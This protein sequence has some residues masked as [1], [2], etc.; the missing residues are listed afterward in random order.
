[1]TFG[2]PVAV[3]FAASYPHRVQALVLAGGFAKYSTADEPSRLVQPGLAGDDHR[4]RSCCALS[5]V[6]GTP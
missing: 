6:G 1:M 5:T 3:G 2:C 4:P